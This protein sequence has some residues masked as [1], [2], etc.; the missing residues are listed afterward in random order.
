MECCDIGRCVS[1]LTCIDELARQHSLLRDFGISW[2]VSWL[3]KFPRIIRVL[4]H[5]HCRGTHEH[6]LQ[7]SVLQ[8]IMFLIGNGFFRFRPND[9]KLHVRRALEMRAR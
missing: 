5:T 9:A 3:A 8:T 4:V 2:I 6:P 1:R 7:V